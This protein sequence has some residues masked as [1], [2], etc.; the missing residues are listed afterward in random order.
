MAHDAAVS[1]RDVRLQVLNSFLASPHGKLEE[2][3]PLHAS[4]LERDP[5]FYSRLALWYLDTGEVRDHTVLFVAHLLTADFPELREAGWVLLQGMA[6]FEVARVLDHAKRVIGKTPR[7]LRS[8][9]TSYLRARE[10]RQ[11]QFDGAALR[12]RR[13]L[14]HL[15]AS[16]RINPGARAQAILFDGRPPEDSSLFTLKRLAKAETAEEQAWIILDGKVPY[17]VAIGAVKHVTPALLV[18]LIDAMSPQEVINNLASLKRRGAMADAGVKALVEAKLKAAAGD[19]RVSTLKAKRAAAAADLD[20]ETERVL[21]ETT[22]RRVAAKV[23]IKRPTALFVDKSGSMTQAIE[24]AKQLAALVSAVVSADFRV[25]AFDT[26]A[27][28]VRAATG[29]GRASNDGAL[30]RPALSDWEAAFRLIRADGG[31]SIEAPLAKLARDK[32]HVE[33]IVLVTDE[34]ENTAPFFR[35]AYAE[36]AKEVGVRPSV[37]IVHVGGAYTAFR[38]G[39]QRAGIELL[40]YAF[41]GDYYSL[42]NVLPLLAMPSRAELVDLIM[43]RELP[44]RPASGLTAVSA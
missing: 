12:S 14:K 17:P 1:E 11:E 32:V 36:Y 39:L 3:A 21:T 44:R 25:Y 43:Q 23:E 5:L 13:D 26:A 24:V 4:A 30:G 29:G 15:Y 41:A 8:A 16:L 18:A 22:D 42:P 9:V 35:D 6:P 38:D 37:V 34:G 27:F 31:T 40:E 2:L 7:V 28:E 10:A 20:A 33:Q 19:K